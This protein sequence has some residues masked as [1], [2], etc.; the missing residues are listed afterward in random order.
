MT[1]GSLASDCAGP[2][3][4]VW[5]VVSMIVMSLNFGSGMWSKRMRM[6]FGDCPIVLPGTGVAPT[7]ATCAPTATGRH[8][9]PIHRVVSAPS[10]RTRNRIPSCDRAADIASLRDTAATNPTRATLLQ[11][12][13]R[14]HPRPPRLARGGKGYDA[15]EPSQG[16]A[17]TNWLPYF[18]EKWFLPCLYPAQ[19]TVGR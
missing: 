10:H 9:S 15:H 14:F 3:A 7:S 12:P 4:T 13:A 5:P 6:A 8:T 19:Q 2:P 18:N 1:A 11:Y 17:R 16:S